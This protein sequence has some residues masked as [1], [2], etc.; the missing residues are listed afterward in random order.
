MSPYYQ[1]PIGFFPN[2]LNFSGQQFISYPLNTMINLQQPQSSAY[3]ANMMMAPH[4]SAIQF[5]TTP[6]NN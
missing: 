2:M 1:Q 6:F 4:P 3:Y 5:P